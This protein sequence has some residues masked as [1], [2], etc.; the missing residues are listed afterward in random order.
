M[1]TQPSRV[2]PD[3]PEALIP[4]LRDHLVLKGCLGDRWR[5]QWRRGQKGGQDHMSQHLPIPAKGTVP[6]HR[7]DKSLHH[8]SDCQGNRPTH[9][10]IIVAI[11]IVVII[12]VGVEFGGRV[13]GEPGAVIAAGRGKLGRPRRVDRFG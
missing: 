2:D 8:L 7:P 1:R 3:I 11:V 4:Q 12:V 9:G 13:S 10:S 5:G 6:T